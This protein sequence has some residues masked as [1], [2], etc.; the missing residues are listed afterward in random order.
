MPDEVRAEIGPYFVDTP[1]VFDEDER[2]LP[3]LDDNTAEHIRT[4]L[5]VSYLFLV[6]YCF[7]R[8]VIER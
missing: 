5:T 8:M 6:R 4:N 2:K 1:S 3:K 7:M